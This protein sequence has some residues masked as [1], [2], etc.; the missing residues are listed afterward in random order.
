VHFRTLDNPDTRTFK[1]A[2]F[3]FSCT[4]PSLFINIEEN[5]EKGKLAFKPYSVEKNRE[6]VN[7]AFSQVDFLRGMTAERTEIVVKYPETTK[8]K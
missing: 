5:M 2:E 7:K 1:L 6:L 8:C 3:D 4:T